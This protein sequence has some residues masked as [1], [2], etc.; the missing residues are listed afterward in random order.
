MGNWVRGIATFFIVHGALDLAAGLVC[1]VAVLA[2]FER[3]D[4][5]LVGFAGVLLLAFG[6]LRIWAGVRNRQYRSR[7][8]GVVAMSVGMLDPLVWSCTI[9]FL[10]MSV[11]G[12]VAYLGQEGAQVFAWGESGCSVEQVKRALDELRSS[13]P[14]DARP[15]RGLII[16]LIAVIAVPTPIALVAT[17]AALAIFTVSGLTSVSGIGPIRAAETVLGGG[18]F[19]DYRVAFGRLGRLAQGRSQRMLDR[20]DTR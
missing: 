11:L 16:A 9:V 2:G 5:W 6:V 1:M 4:P 12:L 3:K 18:R 7:T 10:A 19:S 17:M 8:L 13:S 14:A 15:S 20:G